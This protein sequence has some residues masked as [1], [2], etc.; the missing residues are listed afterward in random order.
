MN[1][2]FNLSIGIIMELSLINGSAVMISHAG[3]N[4]IY[5]IS[6]TNS[7][8]KTV[9]VKI[10]EDDEGKPYNAFADINRFLKTINSFDQKKIYDVFV[11]VNENFIDVLTFNELKT[12]L[13]KAFTDIFKIVKVDDIENYMVKHNLIFIPADVEDNESSH[14]KEERTYTPKKYYGL[15]ALSVALKLAVPIWGAYVKFITKGTGVGRKEIHCAQLLKE[16]T[17]VNSRQYD[18]FVTFVVSTHLVGE[19][20]TDSVL[21]G[22]G[23]EEQATLLPAACLVRKIAVAPNLKSKS[24]VS[25]TFS[26]IVYDGPGHGRKH[27]YIK[28]KKIEKGTI[29]EERALLETY[30]VKESISVG[31]LE[32]IA[33]YCEEIEVVLKRICPDIPQR[34]VNEA[35]KL[36]D[37]LIKK[38]FKPSL[39]NIRLVQF[40]IKGVPPQ[41]VP[42]LDSRDLIDLM[43]YTQ[44]EHRRDILARIENLLDDDI[45]DHDKIER[46]RLSIANP[47]N[48]EDY[49]TH[50][51]E[52][53]LA[54]LFTA[55]IH[56]GYP[57]IALMCTAIET[58]VDGIDTSIGNSR[59]QIP[60]EIDAQLDTLFPLRISGGKDSVNMVKDAISKYFNQFSGRSYYSIY[61]DYF[62]SH[63]EHLEDREANHYLRPET[64]IDLAKITIDIYK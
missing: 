4:V 10:I 5:P 11:N 45:V 58:D 60:A 19:T 30:Q 23:T 61:T 13:T 57:S 1:I 29:V 63:V 22:F 32:L 64:P 40:F 53:L 18:E 37:L 52:S 49:M 33:Y 25:E 24:A 62:K 15:I 6:G 14:Y 44:S 12:F 20:K 41:I 28:A 34:M 31:D 16:S 46:L 7:F 36:K 59:K 2:H 21:T 38:N 26:Y 48:P 54:V 47:V 8:E 17:I 39:A 3:D 35:I 42:Q 56:K 27:P 51:K 9:L 43:K 50:A 55:L